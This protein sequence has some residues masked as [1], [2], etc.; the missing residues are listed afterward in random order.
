M[1]GF[2]AVLPAAYAGA[3]EGELLVIEGDLEFTPEL[4]SF[5]VDCEAGTAG[6][7]QFAIVIENG[8]VTAQGA[9]EASSA[10]VTDFAGAADDAGFCSTEPGAVVEC[11]STVDYVF[12]VPADALNFQNGS[13]SGDI[14]DSLTIFETL[15]GSN[16][17]DDVGIDESEAF[18]IFLEGDVA[19]D[20]QFSG[21]IRG[22]DSD[23]TGD[24]L[25]LSGVVTFGSTADDLAPGSDAGEEGADGEQDSDDVAAGD[26]QEGDDGEGE[27]LTPGQGSDEDGDST[28]D[29][30]GGGVDPALVAVGA[31]GVLVVGGAGALEVR[32]RRRR[33]AQPDDA[34][35]ESDDGDERRDSRV[36]LELTYPAGPSPR[37]FSTGWLFGAR[38]IVEG[39]DGP[40][41]A[42]DSVKWSGSGTFAPAVG[43]QSRP[44]FSSHGPNTIMLSVSVGGHETTRQFAVQ[45]VD[46]FNYARINSQSKVAA[47]AHGCPAC[48]HPCS[49]PILTGS[50]TVLADGM[51]A[52][53]VGDTGTHAACCGGNS[54]EIVGGD[55]TV[56][57]DGRPAAQIGSAVQ[58]CGGM[59]VIERR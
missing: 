20:G 35:A 7:G 8:V 14:S 59:G 30:G 56:L 11:V 36:S 55:S 38:C 26:L 47:D 19:A 31:A 42:S 21:T 6:P 4:V 44:A 32:R 52:A 48:P 12:D 1:L 50:P 3:Q 2:L 5:F 34:G 41:D 33:G 58:H 28:A 37:V 16:C 15:S 22:T 25:L 23:G 53:R 29:E 51:P 57:I 45:T 17:S 49:G 54:F 46:P 9:I 10:V 39:A 27:A 24:F 18:S 13:V 43:R 40:S